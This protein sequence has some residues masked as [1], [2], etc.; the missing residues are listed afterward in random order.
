[1]LFLLFNLFRRNFYGTIIGA[2]A[3]TKRRLE[4]QTH[5]S[6]T[7]PSRSAQKAAST[8]QDSTNHDTSSII[9]QGATRLGVFRA[10]KRIEA[11]V[12]SVRSRIR[13]THFFGLPMNTAEFQ[14]KFKEFQV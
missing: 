2:K 13:A 1:M 14:E 11:I 4:T 10:K 12:T 5:T 7:I 6:L 9:I 8:G 3:T